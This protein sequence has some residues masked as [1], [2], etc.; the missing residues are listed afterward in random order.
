MSTTSTKFETAV[1]PEYRPQPYSTSGYPSFRQ[2]YPYYLG[3]HHH[4][5]NRRL[6]LIGTTVAL[7]TLVRATLATLPLLLPPSRTSIGTVSLVERFRF[8]TQGWNS[9]A[10]LL[11]GGFLQGYV[12]AWVGH[13]FFEKNKPATFKHPFYSFLGDLTLWK[14]VFLLQRRP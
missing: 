2:F 12:W 13:F 3:E 4:K 6:H 10:K 14:Q 7:G 8:G 5:I 1:N 11:L 9:I